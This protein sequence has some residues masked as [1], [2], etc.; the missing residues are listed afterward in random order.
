[1][2]LVATWLPVI[3]SAYVMR[4]H[5]SCYDCNYV[6]SLLSRLFYIVV[7]MHSFEVIRKCAVADVAYHQKFTS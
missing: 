7:A 1:M 6:F 4:N 3:F 5:M 2:I